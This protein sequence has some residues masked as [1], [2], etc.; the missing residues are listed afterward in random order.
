MG[1][2]KRWYCLKKR[3]I[4]VRVKPQTFFH[5]GSEDFGREPIQRQKENGAN[6]VGGRDAKD[7][8]LETVL[9]DRCW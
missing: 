1:T 3:Q 8:G 9:S 4:Y 7:I 6:D 2:A 5:C